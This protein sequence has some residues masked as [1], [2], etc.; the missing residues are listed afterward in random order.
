MRICIFGNKSTTRMLI[1]NLLRN[2]HNPDFLLTLDKS[3]GDKIEI[4]GGDS[5]LIHFAISNNI[6]I[7]TTSN[8]SLNSQ[9]DLKFFKDQKFD[10]GLCTGWQ[11]LIPDNIIKTFKFGIY[12]WHGSGLE[13]PNGRGRSPLNWSIRLGFKEVHHNLFRYS[14]GAD[15]GDVFETK[16][17][18]IDENDYISDLQ[19]KALDHILD[20]SIRLITS[21][22]LD[23]LS[24]TKQPDHPFITF[25]SLNES[26]GEIFM[27]SMSCNYALRVIRSCS[28]PFPGA[29]IIYM[30]TKYRIWKADFTDP[31]VNKFMDSK[32]V[33]IK[34]GS[35]FIKLRDGIIKCSE[36]EQKKLKSSTS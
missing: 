28:K 34:D 4:S 11:R 10:L 13:F 27:E 33:K 22:K 21:L 24:L 30:G 19:K 20:S 18:S 6:D 29:Y 16:T 31:P 5:N 9:E 25:P 17:F 3:V 14:E 23:N 7:F 35:L 36:F 8:Y 2:K 26:S 1:E 32:L 15:D 12:G